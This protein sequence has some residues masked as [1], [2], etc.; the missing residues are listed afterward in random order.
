MKKATLLVIL[1]A[2]SLY[3]EDLPLQML[4]QAK[5][6]LKKKVGR[7]Y[8][9]PV[10][11]KIYIAYLVKN[12]GTASTKCKQNSE[13]SIVLYE[14]QDI[15]WSPDGSYRIRASTINFRGAANVETP[16]HNEEYRMPDSLLQK[17]RSEALEFRGK[18][19]GAIVPVGKVYLADVDSASRKIFITLKGYRYI[20]EGNRKGQGKATEVLDKYDRGEAV[21]REELAEAL[22]EALAK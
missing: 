14:G 1:F 22:R 7:E 16:I 4:Q 5:P 6:Q 17:M 3:S 9:W 11:C 21:T 12:S 20:D 2:G 10:G 15:N 19:E 13:Y 18:T 8:T